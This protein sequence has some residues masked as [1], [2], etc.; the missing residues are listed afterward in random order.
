MA[1]RQ[2]RRARERRGT[3][4]VVDG[5]DGAGKGVL[6]DHMGVFLKRTGKVFDA[7]AFEKRTGT[8]PAPYQWKGA[9][10]ILSAEPTHAFL[11]TVI[12]HELLH[13]DRTYRQEIIAES[14]GID[15]SMHYT[16]VLEPALRVGIHVIQERFLSTSLVYGPLQ[17]K[18]ITVSWL[19]NLPG[20]RHAQEL[21]PDLIIIADA[22]PRNIMKRLKARLHKQDNAIFEKRAFQRKAYEGFH[23]A[24][25]RRFFT[26]LGTKI[27]YIDM[28]RTIP[29][30][31]R[32]LERIVQPYL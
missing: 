23:A 19:A 31:L 28:N 16:A 21:A 32:D 14:Y 10:A 4:I 15:R 2:T 25:F 26:R 13:T 12:R 6:V 9:K 24:W 27:V 30:E 17:N 11:G 8:F 29:E 20:N 22:S 7:R 3:F 1:L 5:L 18:K